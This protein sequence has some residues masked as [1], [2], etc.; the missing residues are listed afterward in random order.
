MRI[1]RTS[2]SVN[3]K[4]SL[5]M[6]STHRIIIGRMKNI[7]VRVNFFSIFVEFVRIFDVGKCLRSR[8]FRCL[9]VLVFQDWLSF[10]PLRN[11]ESSSCSILATSLSEAVQCCVYFNQTF[12]KMIFTWN[13]KLLLKINIF[14]IEYI[15]KK[16]F[17]RSMNRTTNAM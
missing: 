7:A 10:V 6:L 1:E 5:N 13:S 11:R 17:K 2:G 4:M 15:D 16:S 8:N 12:K 14:E 3:L 9:G